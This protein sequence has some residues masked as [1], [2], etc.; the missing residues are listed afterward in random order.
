MHIECRSSS[1]IRPVRMGQGEE[2]NRYWAKLNISSGGEKLK[3]VGVKT[4]DGPGLLSEMCPYFLQAH[5]LPIPS[6][7]AYLTPSHRP[8]DLN[9]NSPMQKWSSSKMK[10]L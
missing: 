2:G 10:T 1:W 5:S 9:S 7:V 3:A 8:P 6:P 4:Q